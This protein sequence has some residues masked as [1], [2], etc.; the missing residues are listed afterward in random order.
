MG[1]GALDGDMLEHLYVLPGEQSRGVGN[2]LLAK[3]KEVSP[4][5]LCLWTFQ[6]N[7]PAR[8][9]YERCGFTA[10]EF[11]DGSG[12]EEGKLDVLSRWIPVSPDRG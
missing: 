12:N 10:V 6:R 5:G 2:R 1:I 9:F 11:G 4:S 7:T 3:A 8:A